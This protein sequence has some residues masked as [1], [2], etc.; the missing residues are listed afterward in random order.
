MIEWKG[1]V[2]IYSKKIQEQ[3]L[4]SYILNLNLQWKKL[5]NHNN[6]LTEKMFSVL[7]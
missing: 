5:N 4:K 2:D 7:N 6:Q 1:V 3:Q